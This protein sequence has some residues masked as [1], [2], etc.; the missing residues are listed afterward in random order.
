MLKKIII[1][2]DNKEL[3]NFIKDF[4]KE[5]EDYF[6]EG[7]TSGSEGL[8]A[9]K[10]SQPDLVLVDLGLE[11]IRGETICA[12]LRKEYPTLPIIILTGEKSPAM[13]VESLNLGADDY[14]TKPFNADELHARIKA[15]LRASGNEPQEKTLTSGDLLMNLDKLEVTRGGKKI[16]LTAKE[17]DLLKF[18]LLNKSRVLSREKILDT[19][20]G[21]SPLAETRLVDVHVGKL[22]R[23]V[24][25]GYKIQLIHTI[26][27]FG[28]KID[29]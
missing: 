3:I 26:R 2:E 5:R 27:G 12:E 28:Y 17:F 1:I 6:V 10:K 9:I 15:R 21:F 24:D 19:V 16:D 20:W 13:V 25:G 23:K 11:D 29:E 22:R 18:L 4:L 8:K 7:F 14:I